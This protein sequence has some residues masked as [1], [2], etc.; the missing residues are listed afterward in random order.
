MVTALN[1]KL[2]VTPEV[3]AKFTDEPP[4]L[5]CIRYNPPESHP[6]HLF[7][8]HTSSFAVLQS[9]QSLYMV[10][11]VRFSKCESEV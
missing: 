3:P 5:S 6:L 11:F 10:G 8:V 4:E 9:S 2:T 1:V 7:D